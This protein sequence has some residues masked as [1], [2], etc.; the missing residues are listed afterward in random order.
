MLRFLGIGLVLLGLAAVGCGGA[1]GPRKYDVSGNVTFDGE[2]I[3]KGYV[4]FQPVTPHDRAEGAEIINGKFALKAMAGEKKVEIRGARPKEEPGPK[5]DTVR[6][7][8][9]FVPDR[10]NKNTEL[11]AK[12]TE[13]AKQNEFDFRLKSTP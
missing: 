1:A 2:P 6:T 7:E 4:I 9:N 12:V 13:N 10:Y 8:E 11:T 5:G 3:K